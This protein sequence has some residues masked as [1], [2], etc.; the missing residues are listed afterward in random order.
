M[1]V[2]GDDV[3]KPEG[4]D[5]TE[6]ITGAIV[7]LSPLA[8]VTCPWFDPK[9]T[10]TPLLHEGGGSM[11]GCAIGELGMKHVL[12]LLL[13]GLVESTF[14]CCKHGRTDRDTI[15]SFSRPPFLPEPDFQKLITSRQYICFLFP[16][17]I[18]QYKQKEMLMS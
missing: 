16:N 12:S 15:F 3:I 9:D 6:L 8:T 11:N 2:S 7:R 13:L 14:G 17:S 10:D 4:N 1:V 18:R 5:D